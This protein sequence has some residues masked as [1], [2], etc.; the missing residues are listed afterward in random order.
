MRTAVAVLAVTLGFTAA[1]AVRDYWNG[2][3]PHPIYR[4]NSFSDDPSVRVASGYTLRVPRPAW[5]NPAAILIAGLGVATGVGLVLTAR[6]P[7]PT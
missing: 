7:V 6:R 4:A 2:S 3:S 1:V 5:V